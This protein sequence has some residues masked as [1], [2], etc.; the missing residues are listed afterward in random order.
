[1]GQDRL[2]LLKRLFPMLSARLGAVDRLAQIACVNLLDPERVEGP[3]QVRR[4]TQ[5]LGRVPRRS[6]EKAG[7]RK[8]SLGRVDRLWRLVVAR[9]LER[10]ADPL[11]E[12]GIADR[13]QPGQE[14]PAAAQ[15][16]ERL[17]HGADGAIV[18]KQD[19]ALG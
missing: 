3:R 7:E 15:P 1:M 9:R 19:A 2:E 11:A 6:R 17:G 10:A 12:I 13:N 4:Q 5:R 8:R 16:H 14:E 18:G